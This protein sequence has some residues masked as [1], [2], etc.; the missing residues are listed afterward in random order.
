MRFRVDVIPVVEAEG[1]V[2]VFL[3]LEHDEAAQ[4]MHCPRRQEDAVADLRLKAGQI[5]RRGPVRERGAQTFRRDA[6]FQA[7]IDAGSGAVS[8]TTQ[9]SVLPDSPAGI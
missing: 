7:R 4:R 6:G 3:H 8:S 9:A 1:H 5:I 2:A